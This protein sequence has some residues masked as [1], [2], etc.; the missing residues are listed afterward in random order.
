MI[1]SFIE[2]DLIG[3]HE[4]T[5]R[6]LCLASTSDF[7]EVM[8]LPG[9][10]LRKNQSLVIH[11]RLVD[12]HIYIIKKWVIDF[13]VNNEGFSTFKGELL[14]YIIRKQMSRPGPSASDGDKP[15]SAVNVNVKVDDIFDVS[16]TYVSKTNIA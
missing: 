2:R 15:F 13:L 4:E 14:P 9:H 1:G 6:L 10:L 16:N 5:N 11:S 7:E 8:S 12:A 3:I